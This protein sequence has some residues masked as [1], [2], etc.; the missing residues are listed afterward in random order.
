M[1]HFF[2]FI[3]ICVKKFTPWKAEGDHHIP[4]NFQSTTVSDRTL[5]SG[6]FKF[7]C[8]VALEIFAKA[9]RWSNIQR[10]QIIRKFLRNK[11]LRHDKSDEMW[12]DYRVRSG[13][14]ALTVTFLRQVF[15]RTFAVRKRSRPG[16]VRCPD[17]S[18]CQPISQ[19][20][21]L[22]VARKYD[23]RIEHNVFLWSNLQIVQNRGLI[24]FTK[25]KITTL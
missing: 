22:Y 17:R 8:V 12:Y 25:R 3:K 24:N 5:F 15:Q 10:A 18:V 16:N 1:E 7:H 23:K 6:R 14:F 4:S 21:G 2:F 19:S 9:L 20:D 13:T 11:N